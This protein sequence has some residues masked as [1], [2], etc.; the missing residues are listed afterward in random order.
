MIP[1]SKVV[2]DG[3]IVQGEDLLLIPVQLNHGLAPVPVSLKDTAHLTQ[4]GTE[5]Y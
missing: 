3:V 1:F 2:A 5:M 4:S